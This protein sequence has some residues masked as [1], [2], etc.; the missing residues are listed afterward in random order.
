MDQNKSQQEKE[1]ES[2]IMIKLILGLGLTRRAHCGHDRTVV[3]F[4]TTCAI[5]A[6]R[7]QRCE[8]EFRS[9]R[10]V[11]DTPFCDKICQ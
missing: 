7:Y 10:G 8:F 3:G 6:Y 2:K 4:K 5:S 1:K 9:W 11:F